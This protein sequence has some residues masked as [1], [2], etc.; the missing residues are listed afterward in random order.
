[1]VQA[2]HLLHLQGT[3]TGLFGHEA[4]FAFRVFLKKHKESYLCTNQNLAGP[5]PG[6]DSKSAAH[7]HHHTN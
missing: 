5:G 7:Q 3:S 2:L 6:F 1:M 4:R